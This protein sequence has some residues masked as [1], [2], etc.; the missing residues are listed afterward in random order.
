[1]AAMNEE[2][3]TFLDK[4]MTWGPWGAAILGIAVIVGLVLWLIFGLLDD[5]GTV[6]IIEGALARW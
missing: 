5:E 2:R 3:E 6:E 1:M 4:M